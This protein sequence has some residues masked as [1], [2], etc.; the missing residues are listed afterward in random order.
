M[1]IFIDYTNFPDSAIRV[2]QKSRYI[3]VINAL[4]LTTD[5]KQP[6]KPE[7]QNSYSTATHCS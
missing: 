6:Q 5:Y 1:K 7:H 2:L 4:R 3:L